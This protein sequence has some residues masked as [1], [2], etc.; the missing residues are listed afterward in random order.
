M[1]AGRKRREE[2]E[3]RVDHRVDGAAALRHDGDLDGR[4]GVARFRPLRRPRSDFASARF[5]ERVKGD[6]V[7]LLV[8]TA[9]TDAGD[10]RRVCMAAILSGSASQRQDQEDVRARVKD[11]SLCW[12]R[13][14]HFVRTVG[15]PTGR[16]LLIPVLYSYAYTYR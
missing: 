16:S 9:R 12:G 6:A 1:V 3:D 8:C 10:E 4:V 15:V 2:H 13:G 7:A 5:L 14:M 11:A